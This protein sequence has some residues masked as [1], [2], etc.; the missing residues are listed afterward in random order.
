MQPSYPLQNAPLIVSFPNDPER[1]ILTIFDFR[2]LDQSQIV[3]E[4]DELVSWHNERGDY[5]EAYVGDVRHAIKSNQKIA[6][7]FIVE[8]PIDDDLQVKI[9][10]VVTRQNPRHHYVRWHCEMEDRSLGECYLFCK[11]EILAEL[12]ELGYEVRFDSKHYEWRLY[13]L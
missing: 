9:E 4:D 12:K 10:E 11:P 6:P 5:V 3:A 13:E 7:S 8:H 1:E 2:T